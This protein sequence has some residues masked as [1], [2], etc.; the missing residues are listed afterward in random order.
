V[1][2]SYNLQAEAAA[3]G[4]KPVLMVRFSK[5]LKRERVKFTM[6]SIDLF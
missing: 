2:L 4:K 5:D 3:Q 6:E 1:T